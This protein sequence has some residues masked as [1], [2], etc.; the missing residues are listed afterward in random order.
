[1]SLNLYNLPNI[2]KKQEIS[3]KINQE[4][5][6]LINQYIDRLW[7]YETLGKYDIILNYLRAYILDIELYTRK[8]NLSYPDYIDNLNVLCLS[9]L[10]RNP[11]NFKINYSLIYSI[12]SEP[13]YLQLIY[14]TLHIPKN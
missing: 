12:K 9:I 4:Y 2:Q 6:E 14:D 3:N 7:K 5:T 1:M 8:Y 13:C 10:N 11:E